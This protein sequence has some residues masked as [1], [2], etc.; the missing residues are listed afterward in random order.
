[1]QTVDHVP[2]VA[3]GVIEKSCTK[4]DA[5]TNMWDTVGTLD[6]VPLSPV[7]DG[8]K[9]QG[10][11]TA[12]GTL[13]W[14]NASRVA[15]LLFGKLPD[16]TS[17]FPVLVSPTGQTEDCAVAGPAAMNVAPISRAADRMN[18]NAS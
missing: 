14:T 3:G 17:V 18:C 8:T 12:P 7:F 15:G 16:E 1:M 9:V 5:L 11:S 13:C 4:S 2:E 6:H 10:I